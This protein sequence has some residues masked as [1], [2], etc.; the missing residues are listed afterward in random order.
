MNIM[1]RLVVTIMLGL[2]LAGAAHAAPRIGTFGWTYKNGP[3]VAPFE[4][5]E[6]VVLSARGLLQPGKVD[7]LR[8]FGATPLVW[9]QPDIAVS[10]GV[11]ISGAAQYPWDSGVLELVTFRDALLKTIDGQPVQLFPG[12]PS[13][14]WLLDFRDTV[15]VDDYAR[16]TN[17]A[18][19]K[20]GGFVHDYGCGDIGWARLPGVDPSIWPAWRRGYIR[21]VSKLHGIQ[22]LQCDNQWQADLTPVADGFYSEQCGMSINPAAK[23]WANATRYPQ[24]WNLIRVEELNYQKRRLFAGI[25]RIAEARFNWCDL[26]GDYG[27]GSNQNFKPMEYFVMDLGPSDGAWWSPTPGV[28][29]RLFTRGVVLVNLSASSYVYRLS[30]NVSYTIQ[31]QDGITMQTRGT[32]GRFIRRITDANQ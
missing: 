23:V 10:G 15:F 19:A 4:G 24:K 29:Q 20:A 17:Q 14:P 3:T 1:K 16:L 5:Y 11:P 13:S 21:W 8:A 9:L 32:D 7:S 31:P 28:Y 22:I 27:G 2:G 26:R 30:K 6:Y 18:L 25:A 12:N